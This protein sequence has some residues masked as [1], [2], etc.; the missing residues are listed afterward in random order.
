MVRSNYE[1][2]RTISSPGQ[3][4]AARVITARLAIAVLSLALAL[5]VG[6]GAGAQSADER[7][8]T[9]TARAIDARAGH[10]SIDLSKAKGTFT[11]VRI[12]VK[13]GA[14]TLTHVE[15]TYGDGTIYQE[16]RAVVLRQNQKTRPIDSRS[17]DRFLDRIVLTFRGVAG[18]LDRATIAIEGL[19]SPGGATA[20]RGPPAEAPSASPLPRNLTPGQPPSAETEGKGK[21]RG[22]EEVTIED[23]RRG[24]RGMQIGHP[25]EAQPPEPAK[26]PPAAPA[27]LRGASEP[28]DVV[29][30]F[31]GTD[32][33]READ[34]ASNVYGSERARRLELGRA[35]ITVPKVHE[36]PIIERP[37]VYRLPFTQ[38]VL[39]SER[40]DPK[41]HF[42]VREVRRLSQEE[43][44]R[45]VRE[46]L[47]PSRSYKNHALVFVHGFNC[48]FE[49]ALFRTAQIAYDIQFDGAP[50]LYSWPSKGAVGFHDYSYDRESSGQAEPY[51]RQFLEM[52]THET[53]AT[54]VSVIA[55][56]MGSQLLLPVLRDL[57]RAPPPGVAISEVIL[58]APDVDRDAF[59]NIAAELAGVSRGITVLAASNDFALDISRRFW[60]G[61]PR[62]GDVPAGG[63]IVTAGVDTIDITALSTKVF[64][65]NHSAYAE[66]S[67]LLS[68]IQL[69]IQT[70]ERPPDKREPILERVKTERGD[71]W[72]YPRLTR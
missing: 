23:A 57:K 3:G 24:V 37:W 47:A 68:D 13:G 63:P 69:L 14:L 17:E 53:G 44:L 21:G 54:S 35:L 34:G 19:Q 11:A 41:R 49:N 59:E 10:A 60:G 58:A 16:R 42:T 8:V 31:Y 51:L 52:V 20:V 39:A 50:F 46:R 32:R 70:G 6:V 12:T 18:E 1:N 40:E 55:H 2:E 4:R 7:W 27:V 72:R 29:P 66:K 64:A 56:S 61:V 67:A 33:N 22:G 48:S 71:Y 5:F 62:A 43:F 36:T 28:W 25:S 30:V 45:L 65:L 9:L 26:A 15:L 38:I